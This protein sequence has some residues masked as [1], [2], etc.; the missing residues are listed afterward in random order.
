MTSLGRLISYLFTTRIQFSL[1]IFIPAFL[2]LFAVGPALVVYVTWAEVAGRLA[3]PHSHPESLGRVGFLPLFVAVSGG[4]ALLVGLLLAASVIRPIRALLARGERIPVE[5]GEA[6]PHLSDDGLLGKDFKVVARSFGQYTN[7]LESMTGGV[8]TVNGRGIV[9]TFN[10]SAE[11]IF[12]CR[13]ADAVGRPIEEVCRAC[14]RA[15]DFARRIRETLEGGRAATSDESAVELSD[16][17]IVSLGF[18]TSLLRGGGGEAVGV[19]INFRDLG[20]IAAMHRQ[21][22]RTQ[23][24]AS[25]GGLAAGV[26]HEV[27]NPLGGMKGLAQLLVEDFAAEDPRRRYAQTIIDETERLNRVV[28]QL[29]LFAQPHPPPPA[30]VDV[31][32]VLQ[33]VVLLTERGRVSPSVPI[34]MDLKPDLPPLMGSAEQI[35]QAFL[36]LVRNAL[37]AVDGGGAVRLRTYGDTAANGPWVVVEVANTG[38]LPEIDPERLFDPFYSTKPGGTGLG[39]TITHQIVTAHGGSIEVRT[40]GDETVF[41]VRLPVVSAGDLEART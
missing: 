26:A 31:N 15:P 41:T 8:M 2:V 23:R 5:P 4:T 33:Q 9:T 13:S 39:L 19:V 32:D 14:L 1:Y 18:T 20:R 10:P 36:N 21:I 35:L 22:Q 7:I 17:R 30:S 24:L 16:G 29:L 6:P 11:R 25:L 12:S 40:T 27:R 28:E 37:D 34:E 38:R 3:G